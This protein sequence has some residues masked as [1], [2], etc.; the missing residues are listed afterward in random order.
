MRCLLYQA[1]LIAA[2]RNPQL[3]AL[4]YYFKTRPKNPL[5]PNQ[6][7]IAVANKLVRIMFALIKKNEFYNPALVLGEIRESQLKVA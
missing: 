5:K 2:A 4:Y 3:R 7:L 6:A 1:A